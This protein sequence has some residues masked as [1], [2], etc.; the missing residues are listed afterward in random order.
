MFDMKDGSKMEIPTRQADNDA[1]GLLK[2][3]F[4]GGQGPVIG[5]ALLVVI[6]CLTTP[7]FLSVRN[8]LNVIDQVT[9]NGIMALGMTFVIIIGG[10]DLSVGS[11]FVLAMMACGVLSEDF[12]VPG[13][14]A[15]VGGILAASLTG[16]V[17][18]LLVT[19]AKL[20]AFIATMAMMKIARGA[21]NLISD[22]RQRYVFPMWF[23]DLATK[24][25]FEGLPFPLAYLGTFPLTTLLF[26]T[27]I[28]G[29]WVF[30][31]YRA[32]GRK[33][34]AIGGNAEV[35][36][37]AGIRVQSLTIWVYILSATLAGFAGIVQTSRLVSAQPYAGVGYELDAIA[38]VV[39]GG[40]SLNG[41]IGSIGGT[42]IGVLIT[43]ILRNGLT[44]N[45]VTPHVQTLLIGVVIAV[46]VAL[47]VLKKQ[48]H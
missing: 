22:M 31:S 3:M 20:P 27:L 1:G 37:L 42:I 26:F 41:G 13:Q 28:I 6:L 16:L 7:A 46:S 48:K 45:D 23:G 40:A 30:L 32:T 36:R 43:G 18:G 8:L 29:C 10:I 38:A 34:Y 9:R 33:L 24:N 17:N 25:Y 35:A 44:L 5:L 21:A 19:K 2:R 39:I 47:D 14:L 4:A 15:I 12:N 11:A